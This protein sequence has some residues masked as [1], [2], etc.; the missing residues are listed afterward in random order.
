MVLVVPAVNPQY[1]QR[2]LNQG[3]RVHH[4]F[5]RTAQ[6]TVTPGYIFFNDNL[7]IIR[8][9]IQAASK[10]LYGL[11]KLLTPFWLRHGLTALH[12]ALATG[13]HEC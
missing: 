6:A 13:H 2:P 8:L 5:S 9:D 1:D 12:S 4:A 3:L 10:V 11:C 7:D